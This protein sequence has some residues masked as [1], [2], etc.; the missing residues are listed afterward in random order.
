MM[1]NTQIY[2]KFLTSKPFSDG[3]IR[4]TGLIVG[5]TSYMVTCS[6][7]N[8]RSTQRIGKENNLFKHGIHAI[9]QLST[10]D[11]PVSFSLADWLFMTREKRLFEDRSLKT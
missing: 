5:T 4:T 9:E 6:P 1:R 3:P 10:A 2:L 8:R 7:Y 11:L